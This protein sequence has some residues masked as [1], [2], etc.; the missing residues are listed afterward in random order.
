MWELDYK[1]SRTPRNWW[2]ST[3]VLEKTWESLGLQGTASLRM[4]PVCPKGNQSWIFIG[5]TDVE[6]EAPLLWPPDVKSWLIWK[7]PDAGKGWRQRRR[8]WQRMRWL[9]ASLTQ[10]IWVWA[11]SGSWWWTGKPGVLQS[12][13]LQIVGHDWATEVIW[14][15]WGFCNWFVRKWN[16]AHNFSIG[17]YSLG[18]CIWWLWKWLEGIKAR[19]E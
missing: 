3:V 15:N 14:T 1:E 11:N 16:A 5:R 19:P 7:D 8:G 17:E 4:Q 6:A 9:M 13:G 10:W 2:L 18:V 12:M